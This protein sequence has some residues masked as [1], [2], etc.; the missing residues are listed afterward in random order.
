V[1]I[2]HISALDGQTGA[3]IAAARIHDGLIERGITSRLCV[4]YPSAGLR[5]AFT[6]PVTLA[7]RVART[8]RQGIGALL[9]APH[10]R[11]YDYVLSTGRAGHDIHRIVAAEQPDI[12]HLHWI[13]GNAFRLATLAGISAPIV[14]RLSDMWPFCGLAHLEPDPSNYARPPERAAAWPLTSA[15]FPERVRRRKKLIYATLPSLT[16]A[17]PS[18]WLQA[19]T[20]RSALLGDRPIELIPTSCDTSVF[21]PRDR[22][23]CREALGLSPD[24]RLVLVGATSMGTHWKGGDLFVDAMLRLVSAAKPSGLRIL[25]FGKDPMDAPALALRVTIDHFGLVRDRHL[26]TILYNAADVFVAPSRME[27]LAN[28]VLESLAC[29]TPVAAFD[30]GGMPDMIEHEVNGCLAPP[31]DTG[32]LADG[33]AWALRQLGNEAV[34]QA[35]RN[36]ILSEFSLEQE[37]DKYVTLY[38]RVLRARSEPAST[39]EPAR[40]V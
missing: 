31:F 10:A 12:V 2:L 27:N 22:R 20:K 4:A 1:K 23:A 35:A 33:I 18:R 8:L 15:G 3:G 40:A 6:P 38:Q 17:V 25:T 34:R 32:K 14:W 39:K 36:K 9:L 7:G 21:S 11:G 29:G 26:M 37:I 5:N 24:A 13:A 19:E 16:L 28:T 30:I